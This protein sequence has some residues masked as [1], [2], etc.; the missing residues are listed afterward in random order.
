MK[1][2]F[3]KKVI[4]DL[5]AMGERQ[6]EV[7]TRT[8]LYIEDILKKSATSYK[9]EGFKVDLPRVKKCELRVDEKEIPCKSTSFIS[10]EI[11]DNHHLVSSLADSC[12]FLYKPNI[13]FNPACRVISKCNFY[14]APS[15]A[16]RRGDILKIAKAKKVSGRVE[17]KR[18]AHECRNI[19]VGNTKNPEVIIFSHYDSIE[20]GSI[21]NA[22]G[23]AMALYMILSCP[24]ILERALFVF[25]GNEEISYDEPVYW[26]YGYRRFEDKHSDILLGS[27]KIFVL[28]SLG[29]SNTEFIDDLELL[30]LGFGIKS[31]EKVAKKTKVVAGDLDDLMSVYHSSDDLPKRVSEKEVE[32]AARRVI[33]EI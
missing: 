11:K 27:K 8:A 33:D 7:E 30:K 10:G 9:K 4:R 1:K 24:D 25:S 21:D 12:D 28:D 26:C 5:S 20:N 18:E 3:V 17:V 2:G 32:R 6:F 16:V 13:N 23:T 22:S 29:H 14:F 31:L 19:L 15:V